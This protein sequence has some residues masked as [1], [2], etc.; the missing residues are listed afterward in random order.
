MKYS[1]LAAFL[2]HTFLIMT[3]AGQEFV[4]ELEPIVVTAQKR[5]Q[6][7]S[8]VPLSLQFFSG[9]Q[10][11]RLGADVLSD[12]VEFLPNVELFDDLGGGA[13]PTWFI[14]G[15]GLQDFNA[16]NT[17]TTA[18]YMDE[19]YMPSNAMNGIRLFDIERVE[20]L[21]GPQ[22]GLYG[23]NTT[24]G[25]VRVTSRIPSLVENTGHVSL[26]YGR[27]DRSSLE[28]AF[29]GPLSENIGFRLATALDQGE[30]GWQT[31]LASDEKH[32]EPDRWAIRGQLLLAPLENAEVLI[33]VHGSE[34]KSEL[35]LGRAV[36]AYADPADPFPD[37][38]S[39]GFLTFAGVTDIIVFGGS[40]APF[41]FAQDDDGSSVLSD[42][43]NRLDNRHSGITIQ[44]TLDFDGATMTSISNYQLFDHRLVFDYDGSTGE[45]GHQ[46]SRSDIDAWSQ[47]IRLASTD[48]D[49]WTWL[50][51]A[52]YSEDRLAED[53][54]FLT[55]DN[56]LQNAVFGL[57][58]ATAISELRY[59]Q[60]TDA[61]AIFGHAEYEVSSDWRINVALR[62]STEHK[63]YNSGSF[64]FPLAGLIIFDDVNKNYDLERHWSGKV[65][66]DWSPAPNT[67]IYTSVSRGFKSGGFFGG[68]PIDTD[69]ELDPYK[70]ESIWAYELGV[71]ARSTSLSIATAAFYYD[72]A[73]VQGFSQVFSQI[74]QSVVTKL[75]TIGDAR[76][77]GFELD[78]AWV[79]VE[80]LTL[81]L[82]V[83]YLDAEID[84]SDQTFFTFDGV[85][86]AYE[87]L[88]RPY[89]PEWSWVAQV[90]YE[91]TIRERLL[92]RFQTDYSYRSD[93]SADFGSAVDKR[94]FSVPGYGLVNTRLSVG[95]PD[96]R[97]DVAV[98]IKN[99]TNEEYVVRS[100]TD[101]LGSFF[102]LYGLP[103]SYGIELSY[104]W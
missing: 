18:I 42:P 69:E 61:W 99:L 9:S 49:R 31:A 17:P 56:F 94:L 21:K 30:G 50:V 26:S 3:V 47:E 33:K 43:V 20:V 64:T 34:D 19:V 66:L 54:S 27:W 22:G 45:F 92:A 63:D 76:H 70:E 77:Y 36:G 75:D 62:H 10:L 83:G 73:D 52:M 93:R 57:A 90:S 78:A 58:P 55:R 6:D 37:G 23:R 35:T 74:T 15:V 13:R 95:A 71:K 102:D 1:C 59:E 84:D 85:E 41:P 38:R 98:W 4:V 72:Y 40:G 103:R 39:E 104:N 25:V 79:P 101:D 80:G 29:G 60:E 32:G 24:G 51:G 97:W 8:D 46:D 65:G 5:A 14:R 87:G 100:T 96:R 86:V 11:D 12:V 7:P 88:R 82:G 48:N 53:R 67:L 28:A 81:R 44:A 89:A 68:F 16:N 2:I 91:Y